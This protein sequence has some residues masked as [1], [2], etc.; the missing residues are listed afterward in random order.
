MRSCSDFRPKPFL[1]VIRKCSTPPASSSD[2]RMSPEPIRWR[3]W[4]YSI[5]ARLYAKEFKSAAVGAMEEEPV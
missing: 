1:V 3:F 2:R 5:Q 4:C